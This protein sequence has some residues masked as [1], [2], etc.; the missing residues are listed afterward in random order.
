MNTKIIFKLNEIQTFSTIRECN[1]LIL[2][3]Y[4]RETIITHKENFFKFKLYLSI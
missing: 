3:V 4:F 2:V 1:I